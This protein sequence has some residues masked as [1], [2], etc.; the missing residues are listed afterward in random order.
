MADHD[1]EPLRSDTASRL[2]RGGQEDDFVLHVVCTDRG[3]HDRVLLTIAYC[4][5]G[6]RGMSH[7]LHWFAPPMPDAEPGSSIS[8]ESYIFRCPRCPRTA[9]VNADRWWR[10]V[11]GLVG[12]VD[13]LDVSLLPF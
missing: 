2:Q 3:Q 1:D 10:A 11:D 6:E 9:Q 12:A 7:A 5:M 4:R 13:E 8:R